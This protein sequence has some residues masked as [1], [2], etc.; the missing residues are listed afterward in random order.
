VD[1]ALARIAI[2]RPRRGD[3]REALIEVR[4]ARLLP[5]GRIRATVVWMSGSTAPQT[6]EG[7]ADFCLEDGRYL[8]HVGP[9][10]RCGVAVPATPEA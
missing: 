3:A 4:D 6:Y 9:P 2:L 1:A 8:W 7:R 10:R 5:D